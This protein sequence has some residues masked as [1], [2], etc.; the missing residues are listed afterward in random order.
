MQRTQFP[1]MPAFEN[2]INKAQENPIEQSGILM[3]RPVF[4][5]GQLYVV[6]YRFR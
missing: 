3:N 5:H 1:L 4:T 2:T 6:A